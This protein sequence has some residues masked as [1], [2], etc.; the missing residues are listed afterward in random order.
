MAS[1]VNFMFFAMGLTGVS[2]RVRDVHVDDY[3]ITL[4]V[5]REKGGDG[6]AALKLRAGGHNMAAALRRGASALALAVFTVLLLGATQNNVADAQLSMYALNETTAS[7]FV[8]DDVMFGQDEGEDEW[9]LPMAQLSINAGCSSEEKNC[10]EEKDDSSDKK[11][12]DSSSKDDDSSSKDDSEE[13]DDSKKSDSDDDSKKSDSDDDSS[14]AKDDSSEEDDDSKKRDSDD[15]SSEAKDDSSEEDDDSKKRDSDDDSSEAKDDSSEED[16]DSKKRDSDDDSSE[17]KDDSSEEDDDSKKR[18][19]DDDSS[20]AKDDSSEEDDDSK[21]SDSD[22][23]DSKKSDDDSSSGS[24]TP[25]SSGRC[26][27]LG[28]KPRVS[29]RVGREVTSDMKD[30]AEDFYKQSRRYCEDVRAV[31]IGDSI[32]R[33]LGNDNGCMKDIFKPY[34]KKG[35]NFGISGMKSDWAIT[36]VDWLFSNTCLAPQVAYIAIG[37]NDCIADQD[38]GRDAGENIIDIIKVLKHYSPDTQIVVQEVLPTSYPE[39]KF[40]GKEWEDM[41]TYHC[42]RELNRKVRDFVDDNRRSCLDIVDLSGVVLDNGK[43]DEGVLA[44][45]VHFWSDDDDDGD[46]DKY[47]SAVANAVEDYNDQEVSARGTALDWV[48][49]EPIHYP[50][51]EGDTYY[52]WRYNEWS[53]CSGSCGMQRRTAECHFIGV[54]QTAVVREEN[55]RN[56]F[57]NPLER[58]CDIDDVCLAEFSM[59]FGA[60][61]NQP[62]S[63]VI[64]D[65]PIAADP[66]AESFEEEC[67]PMNTLSKILLGC[68]VALAVSLLGAIITLVVLWRNATCNWSDDFTEKAGASAARAESSEIPAKHHI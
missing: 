43:F 59:P 28:S 29:Y 6:E 39:A 55:C 25:K 21:K 2:C 37:V 66:V 23:D 3:I 33:H 20:E 16:D 14:E 60:L 11:D 45:G 65:G 18:D 36:V 24:R 44:D 61:I 9:R 27:D 1:V 19:S 26:R 53:A 8:L 15:D 52:R 30:H 40:N 46:M 10:S 50:G 67:S 38:D 35:L 34:R 32:M 57:M 48:D 54:N 5:Y 7:K 13:D 31:I 63:L 12:D 58:I 47:C 4:Q 42:V 22:D 41:K 56:V 62:N 68:T 17:A 49:V 64:S 51:I